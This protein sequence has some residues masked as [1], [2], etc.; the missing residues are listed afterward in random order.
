LRILLDFTTLYQQ[1]NCDDR[2]TV[3]LTEDIKTT[4]KKN[5]QAIIY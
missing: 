5:R 4:E 2:G 1:Q 3:N